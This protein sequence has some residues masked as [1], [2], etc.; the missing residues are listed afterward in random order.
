MTIIYFLSP[1]GIDITQKC[2]EDYLQHLKISP[3]VFSLTT[4]YSGQINKEY[5]KLV[6]PDDVTNPAFYAGLRHRADNHQFDFFR[7]PR[8]LP[9]QGIIAFDMDSTFVEEEGV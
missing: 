3:S 2:L 4:N 5:L 7:K 6:L 8:V 9:D 1:T